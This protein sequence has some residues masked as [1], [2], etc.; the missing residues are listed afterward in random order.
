MGGGGHGA[1]GHASVRS[2]GRAL[3]SY[4]YGVFLNPSKTEVWWPRLLAGV[5][6]SLP[7]G[8]EVCLAEGARLLGGVV[9]T[10]SYI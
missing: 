5:A 9:S 3:I 2:F 4:N 6:A 7:S 8:V 10:S 1:V